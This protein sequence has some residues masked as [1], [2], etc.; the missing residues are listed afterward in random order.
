MDRLTCNT[1]SGRSWL[2]SWLIRLKDDFAF[3]SISAVMC[4]YPHFIILSGRGESFI[5][6]PESED[7]EDEVESDLLLMCLAGG[8]GGGGAA[9]FLL[10]F[11]LACTSGRGTLT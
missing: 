7:A 8:G 3:F 5:E 4:V 11:F 2:F 6:P 1:S 10:D 9:D